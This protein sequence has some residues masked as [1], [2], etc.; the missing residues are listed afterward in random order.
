MSAHDDA[1]GIEVTM[2]VPPFN[3]FLAYFIGATPFLVMVLNAVVSGAIVAIVALRLG[4]TNVLVLSLAT[5]TFLGAIAIEASF[6]RRNMRHARVD[7]R[8]L[9]PTQDAGVADRQAT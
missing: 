8:S 6:G 9:F 3:S 7:A 5:A 1:E 4:A 2:A